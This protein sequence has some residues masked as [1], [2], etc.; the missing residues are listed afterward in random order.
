MSKKFTLKKLLKM[1]KCI[2]E[3]KYNYYII[4]DDFRFGN[5]HIIPKYKIVRD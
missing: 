3:D 5:V 2:K 1:V 4:I